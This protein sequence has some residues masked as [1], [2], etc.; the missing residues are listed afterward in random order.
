MAAVPKKA[1]PTKARFVNVATGTIFVPSSFVDADTIAGKVEKN[2][3]RK[4]TDVEVQAYL[5]SGDHPAV[6]VSD[7]SDES[8]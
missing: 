4:A 8:E 2:E 3:W 6:G 5:K 1:A 7:E